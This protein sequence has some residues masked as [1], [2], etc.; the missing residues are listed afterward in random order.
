[1]DPRA[2][3]DPRNAEALP[4]CSPAPLRIAVVG[5]GP[6]GLCAAIALARRG[7]HVVVF[8]KL[9]TSIG[10][11]TVYR[12]R[13]YPVDATARGMAA[14]KQASMV[15]LWPQL[16]WSPGWDERMAEGCMDRVG[17]GASGGACW[18]GHL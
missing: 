17:L 14:T 2:T 8:E 3:P 5:G 16:R 18:R 11:P 9:A 13:S 6:G 15:W 7:H 10:K 12:D 4:P 1:M